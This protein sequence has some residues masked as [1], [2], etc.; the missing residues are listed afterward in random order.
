MGL[1]FGIVALTPLVDPQLS[2]ADA[3]LAI[4]GV[5]LVALGL[6]IAVWCWLNGAEKSK[7]WWENRPRCARAAT[8]GRVLGPV[9]VVL[10]AVLTG[11]VFF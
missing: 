4:A 6:G 9:A 3:A 7:P 10:G 2:G 5:A 1:A 11:V 8:A